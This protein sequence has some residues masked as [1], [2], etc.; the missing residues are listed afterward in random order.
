MRRLW[1]RWKAKN[2]QELP[3]NL[4]ALYDALAARLGSELE[5]R[6]IIECRA[7]LAWSDVIISPQR[8]IDDS[9]VIQ[10]NDDLNRRLAGEPLSRIYGMREFWG[11]EFVLSADTL[12]PRQETELIVELAVK[13]LK[14]NPPR[15]MLDLGTGTGCILISLLREFQEAKGLGVDISPGALQTA[16]ENAQKNGV[17][18]RAQF[19]KSDW[20][21][22]VEG[23]F[24]LIVSN[25]PYIARSVIPGLASEVRNHDPI[26][27]LEGGEDGLEAYKKIFSSLFLFLNP[28]GLA[29]FEIGFDQGETVVRLSEESNVSVRGVHRDLAG[30]ARVVE[31]CNGDK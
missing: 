6:R 23:K 31:I 1:Q 19:I 11:L 24:D 28:G 2:L 22:S 18:A 30:M 27:A 29:L 4:K 5:A 15:S 25:P 8:M 14:D 20:F 17:A 21:D 9:R 3:R 12:D 16:Q 10:I 7:G 26:L 13:R